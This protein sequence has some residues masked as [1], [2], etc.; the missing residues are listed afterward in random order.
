MEQQ[1][2]GSSSG[3]VKVLLYISVSLVELVKPRLF[4]VSQIVPG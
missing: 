3:E 4:A 2:Q 1:V